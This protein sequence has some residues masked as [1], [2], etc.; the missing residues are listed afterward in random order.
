MDEI[1]MR[2]IAEQVFTEKLRAT[3]YGFQSQPF[4]THNGTDSPNLPFASISNTVPL[5]ARG[6]GVISLT[7]LNTQTFTLGTEA[8]NGSGGLL[9]KPLKSTVYVYPTPIIYGYGV[10]VHSAFEGGDAPF[11]TL[12]C[13]SNAGTMAQLFIKVDDGNGT[14]GVWFGFTNDVGPI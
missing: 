12:L 7:T 4:H 6:T 10:G 3:Q 1:K 14:G 11:G 13:F 8:V 5:P 9:N 2:Q